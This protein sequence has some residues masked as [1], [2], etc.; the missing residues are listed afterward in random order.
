M[1]KIAKVQI[2]GTIIP[3][4]YKWFY[5]L[6]DMDSTAPKDVQTAIDAA[7]GTE[8]DVYINSGGGSIDAGSEIYTLLRS[9]QGGVKIYITGVAHSAA[10]VIAMAGYSEMSPTALMMVHCVSVA[11]VSGNHNELQ[12]RV[13]MLEA[14]DKAL[15]TAYMEKAGMTQAQA[16]AMMEE[17][18]WLT[19][20]QA[21]SRGM[22]DKVMFEEPGEVAFDMVAGVFRLPS[23][24]QMEAARNLVAKKEEAVLLDQKKAQAALDLLSLGGK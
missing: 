22:V 9:Y 13:E 3:N 11:G 12:K 6:L 10:S 4:D 7:G 2:K 19:A 8:L 1:R 14:A 15:C 5:D 23:K 21:K 17:E 20:E 16:L 24:D 18:T